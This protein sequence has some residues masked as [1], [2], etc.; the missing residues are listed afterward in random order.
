MSCHNSSNTL[1]ANERPKALSSLPTIQRRKVSVPEFEAERP[2]GHHS[3][4]QTSLYQEKP[5]QKYPETWLLVVEKNEGQYIRKG[6]RSGRVKLNQVYRLPHSLCSPLLRGRYLGRSDF[7]D[8]GFLCQRPDAADKA[9]R[10]C[11]LL[12]AGLKDR[13]LRGWHELRRVAP[14]PHARHGNAQGA[15]V[16]E[17][18]GE[19]LAEAH[20]ILSRPLTG[21]EAHLLGRELPNAG[22]PESLPPLVCYCFLRGFSSRGQDFPE[23]NVR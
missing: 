15:P 18:G 16:G 10:V 19:R 11:E 20:Q 1:T 9:E 22:T 2:Q 5:R 21:A 8:A 12:P 14:R 17:T 7:A 4:V 23:V 3:R 6:R 13:A